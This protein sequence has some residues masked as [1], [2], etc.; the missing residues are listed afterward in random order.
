[1]VD[2]PRG[3]SSKTR[4]STGKVEPEV[5]M[6]TGASPIVFFRSDGRPGGRGCGGVDGAVGA[7]IG[8]RGDGLQDLNRAMVFMT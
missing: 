6:E 7:Q 2:A 4:S 1:M 3:W 8:Q 5:V